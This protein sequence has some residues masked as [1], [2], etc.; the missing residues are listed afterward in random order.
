M[1]EQTVW[2]ENM[3]KL[4]PAAARLLRAVTGKSLPGD[5]QEVHDSVPDDVALHIRE[6]QN[7]NKALEVQ[8]K[9]AFDIYQ[10]QQDRME[11]MMN[12]VKAGIAPKKSV[13]GAPKKD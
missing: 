2:T 5:M 4:T 13:L 3:P 11:E 1:S 7:K 12:S 6:L 10:K 9:E 8:M